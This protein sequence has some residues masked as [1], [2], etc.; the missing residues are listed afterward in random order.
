M[1]NDI[2]YHYCILLHAKS[3]TKQVGTLALYGPPDASQ[4]IA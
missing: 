4:T 2:A 1:V 3:Q